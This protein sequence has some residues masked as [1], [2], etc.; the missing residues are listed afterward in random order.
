MNKII[1]LLTVLILLTGCSLK[2][3]QCG[4]T[5]CGERTIKSVDSVICAGVIGCDYEYTLDND[6]KMSSQQSPLH[7]NENG[8]V[9][10]WE[11]K[12]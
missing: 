4:Y 3:P 9:C 10:I 6:A 7:T 12:Q 8:N 11:C 5:K 2:E 1:I